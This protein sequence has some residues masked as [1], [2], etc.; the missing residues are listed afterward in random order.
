MN[1]LK[2]RDILD[3]PITDFLLA[4]R[5][6]TSAKAVVAEHGTDVFA[7][8]QLS[9]EALDPLHNFLV[10]D[11]TYMPRYY[12][13]RLR[14]LRQLGEFDEQARTGRLN[15]ILDKCKVHA[16]RDFQAKSVPQLHEHYQTLQTFSNA[17]SFFQV[18]M[19]KPPLTH[20]VNGTSSSALIV[21]TRL[22]LRHVS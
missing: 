22:Q 14:I 20:R 2:F 8:K 21:I 4:S 19:M 6:L 7:Q 9:S 3:G 17:D 12:A 5:V 1:I 13:A 11:V 18:G 10:F 15:Q 16:G